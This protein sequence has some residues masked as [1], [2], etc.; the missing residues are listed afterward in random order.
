[1]PTKGVSVCLNSAFIFSDGQQRT[2]KKTS[3][4]TS[5]LLHKLQRHILLFRMIYD[6]YNESSIV[7]VFFFTLLGLSGMLHHRSVQIV[8]LANPADDGRSTL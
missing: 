1:M 3:Q 4:V 7:V 5:Q 6:C 2:S 8:V